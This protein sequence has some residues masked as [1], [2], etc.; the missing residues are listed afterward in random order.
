MSK[1]IRTVDDLY[2]RE[3][4]HADDLRDKNGKPITATATI[5]RVTVEEFWNDREQARE[6]KCVVRFYK[7]TRYLICNKTQVET[8]AE[9]TG[10]RDFADW[11]GHTVRLT[12]GIARNKRP[13]INILE[14]LPQPKPEPALA[15]AADSAEDG[16]ED[17]DHLLY[18]A[19]AADTQ[20]REY[21]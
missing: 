10:S 6:P 16:E 17:D 9:I 20:D 11:A 2:P 5:E 8:L 18:E 4:L 13:T 1:Q 3:W 19:T 7:R 15:V 14:A 21:E 12:P